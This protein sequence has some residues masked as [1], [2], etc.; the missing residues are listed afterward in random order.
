[1]PAHIVVVHNEPSIV[2]PLAVSLRADGH[3][4]SAFDDSLLAW[5]VLCK[6]Q[7]VQLLV[8]RMDFGYGKPDGVALARWARVTLPGVK[9]LFVARPEFDKQAEGVGAFLSLPVS[10]PEVVKAVRRML[11]QDGGKEKAASGDAA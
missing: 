4:V 2:K 9:V 5:D 6:A 7:D 8:T 10:V 1:M 3:E 11:S